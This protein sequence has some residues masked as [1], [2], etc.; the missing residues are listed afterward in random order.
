MPSIHSYKLPDGSRRYWF[1]VDTG[2]TPEGKRIQERYTFAR[3]ADAEGE[4]ARITTERRSGTTCGR[5]MRRSPSC[6]TTTCALP[7]SRRKR[8][9]RAH[10]PT[11]R[12]AREQLGH[13]K[14]QIITRRDV[15]G[16]RDFML[17]E[18]RKIGGK[19]GTGLGARS[20][21]LALGRLQAA[22]AMAVADGRLARN[23]VEYVTRP[24]QTRE[25]RRT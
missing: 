8:Q 2:R 20:V 9:L 13:R 3:K 10:T 1:R 23:P 18:G 7:P 5:P 17:R 15:E 16:I 22:F 24:R 12:C 21:N 19:A 14:M 4:L 25:E 6:L 11:P